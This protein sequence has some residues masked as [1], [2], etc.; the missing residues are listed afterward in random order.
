MDAVFILVPSLASASLVIL[1]VAAGAEA[2]S[3]LGGS[4][5]RCTDTYLLPLLADALTEFW[6]NILTH[7]LL[8]KE[9]A[10]DPT[11]L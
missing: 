7:F 11:E 6:K 3:Q 1:A 10:A 4:S 8:N 5:S 9:Q 2:T